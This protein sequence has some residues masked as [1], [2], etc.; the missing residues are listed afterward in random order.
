MLSGFPFSSRS[1]VNGFTD[2]SLIICKL[3]DSVLSTALIDWPGVSLEKSFAQV[4]LF[5]TF[6]AF[7]ILVGAVVGLCEYHPHL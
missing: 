1:T 4:A 5:T 6:V 7:G 2:L 3:T